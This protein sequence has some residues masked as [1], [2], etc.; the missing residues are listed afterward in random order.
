MTDR[1]RPDQIVYG[2]YSDAVLSPVV[3]LGAAALVTAPV[4]RLLVDGAMVVAA[5]AVTGI[6][7]RLAS[8]DDLRARNLLRPMV[9]GLVSFVPRGTIDVL[10]IT[11]TAAALTAAVVGRGGPRPPPGPTLG[12]GRRRRGPARRRLHPDP[13][14][15]RPRTQLVGRRRI[16]G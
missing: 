8:D 6:V 13:S 10:A 9:L 1:W 4:R 7:L 2:R 3:L 14:G 16:G 11:L 12:A 15:S 5:I